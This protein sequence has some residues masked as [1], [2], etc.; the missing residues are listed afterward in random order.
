MMHRVQATGTIPAP[1]DEMTPGEIE[2]FVDAGLRHGLSSMEDYRRHFLKIG[3]HFA[4]AT[5]DDSWGE[6]EKLFAVIVRRMVVAAREVA[7]A[8]AVNKKIVE[9]SSPWQ[10][11]QL[12]PGDGSGPFNVR[13]DDNNGFHG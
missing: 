8:A 3:R 2:T 10:L 9:A 4:F 6:F 1:F 13:A 7:K 5:A 11:G 12:T